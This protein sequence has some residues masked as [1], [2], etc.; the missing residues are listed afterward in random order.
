MPYD[1]IAPEFFFFTWKL[2]QGIMYHAITLKGK[3]EEITGGSAL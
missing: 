3:G 2:C 1:S